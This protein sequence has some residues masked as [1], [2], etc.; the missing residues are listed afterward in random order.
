MNKPTP[1]PWTIERC[2]F[3]KQDFRIR[4]HESVIGHVW[5][6]GVA[7]ERAE[8]NAQLIAAAPVMKVIVEEG[9]EA[10]RA[11]GEGLPDGYL[12]PKCLSDWLDGAEAALAKLE[13]K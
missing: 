8:A 1:G 5:W 3:N 6:R 12:L 7:P 13:S 10:V 9:I 11:Y 2:G 4:G